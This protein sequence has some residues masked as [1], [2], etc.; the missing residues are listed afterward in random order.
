MSVTFILYQP[1]NLRCEPSLYEKLNSKEYKKLI[2]ELESK[3]CGNE[4]DEK[5]DEIFERSW[6]NGKIYSCIDFTNNSGLSSKCGRAW[7]RERNKLEKF[8]YFYL[9]TYRGIVKTIAA[10]QILYRQGWFLKKRFFKKPLTEIVCTSKSELEYFFKKYID[11]K[12]KDKRG[13]E[14]IEEFR[15][16]WKDGMIFVCSW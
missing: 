11:L 9:T 16:A 2:Q 10:D 4:L 15:K 6:P 3:Y 1:I 5:I 7:K 14:V 12:N 8:N 13:L